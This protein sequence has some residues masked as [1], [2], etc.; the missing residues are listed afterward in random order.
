MGGRVAWGGGV[1]GEGDVGEGDVGEG[2]VGE[3][4]VGEGD[5]GVYLVLLVLL[6]LPCSWERELDVRFGTSLGCLPYMVR[7]GEWWGE[8]G[9]VG[10]WG[11]CLVSG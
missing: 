11:G 10:L 2:G 4:G 7:V 3:G 1:V 5:V 8:S 6:V 9:G